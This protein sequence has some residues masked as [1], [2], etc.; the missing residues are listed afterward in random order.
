MEKTETTTKQVKPENKVF[1]APIG[2]IQNIEKIISK[3]ETTRQELQKVAEGMK[4]ID[5]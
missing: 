5:K 1:F 4:P 2:D 3:L